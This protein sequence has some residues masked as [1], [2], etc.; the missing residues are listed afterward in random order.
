MYN[1]TIQ[2]FTHFF[3][4][5]IPHA[6]QFFFLDSELNNEKYVY[7]KQIPHFV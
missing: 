5:K 1:Y 4:S 2:F 7:E 6:I 3:T